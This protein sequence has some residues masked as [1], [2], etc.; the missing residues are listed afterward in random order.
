ML[1]LVKR[2]SFFICFIL[3]HCFGSSAQKVSSDVGQFYRRTDS[4]M[5]QRF[6]NRLQ[7]NRGVPFIQSPY[8]PQQSFRGTQLPVKPNAFSQKNVSKIVGMPSGPE[9]IDTSMRLVFRKDSAW[10]TNDYITKTRDGNILIPGFDYNTYKREINGHLVKCTQQGDTLWSISIQGGY[11]GYSLDVYKAFELNDGSILL[12]GGMDIPMPVNGR[13]DFMMIRVTATGSLLWEKTFKTKLW[14]AD[15]T[16]GSID[17]Y[18]CR[19][20]ANGDLY[21]GGDVRHYGFSRAALGFKM[22]LAGNILWSRGFVFGSMPLITGINIVNKKVTFLGNTLDGNSINCFGIVTDAATGDTL[23][24]RYLVADNGDFWHSFYEYNMVKLN[25][26]NLA[27]FGPGISEYNPFDTTRVNTHGGMIEVTPDLDFVQSYLFRSPVPDASNNTR[28]TF[29][30]DGSAAYERMSYLSGYNANVI[31]GNFKNGQIVKERVIPYRGLGISWV[32]NFIELDDRGQLVTNFM[33][34]SAAQAG[35]MEFIRLHNSDTPGSCLGHDTLATVIEKTTFHA[36]TPYFDSVS[37]GVLTEDPRPFKGVYNDNFIIGTSCKQTNF[38]DTLHL[39]ALQDTVCENVPVSISVIKNKE[40][41]ANPLWTYDTT[42]ISSF[43][44]L[45]DSTVQVIFDKP[46]QGF[47]HGTIE[48]CKTLEDSVEL[49]VLLAPIKLDLGPDTVICP[50]NTIV[51]NAKR[52]YKTYHW[53]DGTVDS[54]FIVTQPGTYYVTTT[55]ACGGIFSD[56]V[57]VVSHPPIP[58][59][60]GPDISICENDTAII[61]APPGFIHYQWTSY[62]IISDTDQSVKVFPVKSFMYKVEA[63]KTAGCFAFDSIYVT[64]NSAPPVHLGNDTSFCSNQSVTLDAGIGFDAYEWNTGD[65]TEKIVVNKPGTFA[66]K[67]TLRRCSSYDT[68]K[69]VNVYPLPVF[70]LGNDTALCEGQQLQYNFNLP[71]AIYK[72][73]TGSTLNTDTINLPGT[74]WLKVTQMGCISSDTIKV[75]YNPSPFIM[76]GNDTTLCEKQTLQLSAYNDNAVYLWQDGSNA[77]GYLV[78][79]AGTYFVIVNLNNCSASYTIN[80]SYEA[81]PFFTL[82]RDSFLCTGQQYVLQPAINTNANLLWQDGS[83]APSYTV[84]KDG[85]YFLTA[86]NECGSYTDSVTITTGFCNILM[87]T[88]FTPNNDGLDDVFRVKYPFAVKSFN[89]IIYDRWG[90]KVFETNN[91]RD[92]WDGL[93][94]GE[95]SSQGIYVW[96]I[97]FTDTNNKAQQVKGTV[98]LIR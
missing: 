50:G 45:N 1:S 6:K 57:N 73:N 58:F 36:A 27:L 8:L 66:I 85:I 44:Q 2:V 98:T 75:K 59:N 31:Y 14:D 89:M 21:L 41:G 43:Y 78:K 91:I 92:G 33:G 82:G 29:F 11:P 5:S 90:E 87:P 76:L 95:P 22:D 97:S 81:L 74:Y 37:V 38:C 49:T 88:A 40:C 69:V 30:E 56:T 55:D 77:P 42:A 47:I 54:T 93:R 7:L 3:L 13:T 65:A 68:M 20:D 26:G 10:F 80:I 53:Q 4:I 86:T 28:L 67:A 84:I 70:S 16:N 83:S 48:G 12:A 23:S 71:Q 39:L 94:K 79:S 9:C 64:V 19:Q 46:W 52:V 17:I 32:S 51:L 24:S 72:W 63:E 96:V 60:L 62:N 61:T 35:E 15:T 34:D 25:N 18:D